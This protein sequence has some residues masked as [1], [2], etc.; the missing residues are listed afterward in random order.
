MRTYADVF[1]DTTGYVN[2]GDDDYDDEMSSTTTTTATMS[3]TM[4]MTSEEEEDVDVEVEDPEDALP[5]C[6]DM[7]KEQ[8]HEGL[9]AVLPRRCHEPTGPLMLLMD[10]MLGMFVSCGASRSTINCLP[11]YIVKRQV[12]GQDQGPEQGQG[13]YEHER[14]EYS[15]QC[16]HNTQAPPR[17][18]Q[19]HHHEHQ[20]HS[21]LGAFA[22]Q[23][24][25]EEH[26]LCGAEKCPICLAPFE[27]GETVR[28]L[29]CLHVFHSE[30]C[31]R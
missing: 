11:L 4:A 28:K 1:D 26:H 27:D 20:Q 24:Q 5:S 12:A 21:A 25:R 15:N 29:M 30:V 19:P 17:Q 6:L 18:P 7:L 31:T 14:F 23:H 8:V 22:K 16:C 13:Q 10:M 9:K 2:I 3:S